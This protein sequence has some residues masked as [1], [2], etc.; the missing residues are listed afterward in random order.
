MAGFLTNLFKRKSDQGKITFRI[1]GSDG[2]YNLTYTAGE[3]KTLQN[4]AVKNKWKY[5]Y[6]CKPGDYYYFS[7]Q[8]NQRKSDINLKAYYNGKLL[9]ETNDKGDYVIATL[10]GTIS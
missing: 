10:S 2:T 9:K 3:K 5:S 4:P 8:A 7:V 1:K 6:K